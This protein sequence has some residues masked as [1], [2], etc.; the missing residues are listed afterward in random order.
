MSDCQIRKVRLIIIWLLVPPIRLYVRDGTLF[1][2]Y[3]SIAV[4]RAPAFTIYN[5]LDSMHLSLSVSWP[6]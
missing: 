3:L 4:A 6:S 2:D 1:K 5:C